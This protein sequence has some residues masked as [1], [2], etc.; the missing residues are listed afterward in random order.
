MA[1][2]NTYRPHTFEDLIGQDHIKLIL[3]QAEKE[4]SFAH[5]YLLVGP[6]GTGKTTVARIIARTLGA[7]DIDL[8]EIDAA[9]N[10]GVDSMRD[11]IDKAQFSP[12]MSPCKVYIIDEVHMLSK[13][14]FNALLKTL[15]EPPAHV[16][17][18]LAT[19]EVQK[20]PLTIISRCQ[21]LDF[22]RILPENIEKRLLF[23]AEKE[24]IEVEPEALKQ[25]AMVSDGGLRDAL[26]LFQQVIS[27][28][29]VTLEQVNQILGL[30]RK[31]HLEKFLQC[32]LDGNAPQAIELIRSTYAE[33]LNVGQFIRQFLEY[34]RECIFRNDPNRTKL[35]QIA[36]KL[37]EFDVRSS[38]A[39]LFELELCVY[40]LTDQK[41]EIR[42]QKLESSEAGTAKSELRKE[43]HFLGGTVSEANKD[44]AAKVGSH[45]PRP[46]TPSLSSSPTTNHK[47][48]TTDLLSPESLDA[49]ASKF[50][51][52]KTRL[53]F[54]ACTFNGF[55]NDVCH[56][57][58]TSRFHFEILN[59]AE[60]KEELKKHIESVVGKTCDVVF[61]MLEKTDIQKPINNG[62][63][64]HAQKIFS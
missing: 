26:T 47:P 62:L 11:L 18:I 20:L 6:R 59:Q 44:Q 23:V 24:G 57:G 7:Q 30:L 19:T 39:P 25:I 16:Y 1:L 52:S 37:L 54:K 58:I 49:I 61:D 55:Q 22:H 43:T 50:L 10:T 41:S 46:S 13:S 60:V 32:L 21:R 9:S 33:G 15:E 40:A 51:S 45:I 36:E 42:N 64:S 48:Q 28:K 35:F 53:S 63:L 12:S 5:A 29:K 14:A 34:L 2:Y 4:K 31:D 17:F 56:F 27:D 38:S 3:E 8:M